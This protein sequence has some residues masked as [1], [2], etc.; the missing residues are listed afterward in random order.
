VEI[1]AF[2]GDRSGQGVRCGYD[3]RFGSAAGPG[4]AA[5]V[6]EGAPTS[7]VDGGGV[8]TTT[9]DGPPQ[10][11]AV[12]ALGRPDVGGPMRPRRFA[13]ALAGITGLGLA[14]RVGYVLIVTV[15]EN[16]KVYDA[17]WYGV[18]A[19]GLAQGQ[20]FRTP[21]G[22]APTA[23]HPPL[24]S[25]ILGAVT[26]PFGVHRGT[27]LQRLTMAVLGAGVVL[28]V[29]LLGRAVAGPWV[30]LVAAGLAALAPNFWIPNGI[31]MSETPAMLL[32]ALIL[33]G[34]VRLVRSPTWANAALLGVACGAEA[35]VRAEFI[36]FVPTLLVPA[37]LAARQVTV[38][39]RFGLAALGVLAVL[40]VLAPWVG[41][42]LATFKD[43]TYIS[44]GDGLALL[45]ANCPEAYSGQGLG[46]WHLGCVASP[47]AKD[48][49]VKSSLDQHAAIQF[50]QHHAGRLPVVVLARIG[51]LWDFY[52]PAQMINIDVNEGRPAPA[53]RAGLVVYY[54]LLPLA[55][56]GMVILR[57]RGLRQWFL[58]VPAGVLTVVSALFYG[59]VRFRAPFEV[60]LVVLAAPALVVAAR[61]L[62]RTVSGIGRTGRHA[63]GRGA[64]GT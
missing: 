10:P 26:L 4:S 34:V 49:S 15:K 46:T 19:N 35:L 5:V 64:T 16:T 60:C 44:T 54:A 58:L 6:S 11:A 21:F 22:T 38:R 61:G 53:A 25:L 27:G 14:V 3:V 23:A 43:P 7:T 39:R 41:R 18:T 32:M 51:R 13:V 50:A 57:R 24:T 33:L 30:G 28:C 36:L 8:T 48:E 9:V 62:G 20:F 55:L 42:N 52:E 63:T 37:A 47:N 59:S 31:L 2:I 56:A 40:V 17:L 29:G 12:P 1:T 45:G